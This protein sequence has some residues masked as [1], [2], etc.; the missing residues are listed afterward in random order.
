MNFL[1]KFILIVNK[2]IWLSIVAM[3]AAVVLLVARSVRHI[4]VNPP[5]HMMISEIPNPDHLIKICQDIYLVREAG[6][7]ALEQVYLH[8]SYVRI[9]IFHDF[10]I[11]SQR[12]FSFSARLL[13]Y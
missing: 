10:R 5:L 12:L 1:E 9:S 13:R 6:D 7:F 4:I 8:I 3:Y 11:Y 2:I